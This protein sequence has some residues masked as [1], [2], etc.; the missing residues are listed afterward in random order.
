MGRTGAGKSSLTVALFRIVEAAAGDIVIDDLKLGD[1]GLHDI[2]SNM[3]IMP[4]VRRMHCVE[5]CY[6]GI[7]L[8]TFS[9]SIQTEIFKINLRSSKR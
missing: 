8:L 6:P 9:I 3:T 4:Q 7:P 1:I 2:R 5:T